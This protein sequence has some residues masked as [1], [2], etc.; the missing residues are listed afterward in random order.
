[1][2]ARFQVRYVPFQAFHVVG[3]ETLMFGLVEGDL[4]H[5]FTE[6]V[7]TLFY[8]PKARVG[9]IQPYIGLV[10]PLIGLVQPV[11]EVL[12]QL[13]DAV[14]DLLQDLGGKIGSHDFV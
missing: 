14:S 7:E 2:N 1:L 9:L 3:M 5:E 13:L 12:S 8:P 4:T 11:I 6:I 10:E